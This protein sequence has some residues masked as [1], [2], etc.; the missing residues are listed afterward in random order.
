MAS[1]MAIE[2]HIQRASVRRR[3]GA[4]A[5]DTATIGSIWI[6][7]S[8]VILLL[9]RGDKSGDEGLAEPWATIFGVFVLSLPVCWF[10]YQ[11][12]SNAIGVTIGK[13]ILSL[14]I[15]STVARPGPAFSLTT[16]P[17]RPGVGDGLVRT[18]GQTIGVLP[19]GIGY[20]W[21]LW[22]KHNQTWH[23]KMSST[24]VVRILKTPQPGLSQIDSLAASVDDTRLEKLR[25]R[26]RSWPRT[27]RGHFALFISGMGGITVALLLQGVSWTNIL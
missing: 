15:R 12:I 25:F 17:R 23:D 19:L 11:W 4:Y 26:T 3:T 14:R 13:R 20:L 16:D 6:V 8:V 18:I 1:E 24:H 22:D 9:A 10:I 2:T 21:A 27:P 5:L 7:G